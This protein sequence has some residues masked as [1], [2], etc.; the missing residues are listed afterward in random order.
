[1]D[2]EAET[3]P[4]QIPAPVQSGLGHQPWATQGAQP[5]QTA[6]GAQQPRGT[7][8]TSRGLPGLNL[9]RMPDDTDEGRHKFLAC[10]VK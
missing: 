4:A 7:A 2:K 9:S 6:Q 10:H 5:P 1:M 3:Q 8:L